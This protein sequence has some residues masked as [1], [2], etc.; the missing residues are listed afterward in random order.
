MSEPVRLPTADSL[1][2]G[3]PG[4]V[5]FHEARPETA[6]LSEPALASAVTGSLA[7]T[8]RV[9]RTKVEAL[10]ED[11]PLRSVGV[12][13]VAPGEGTVTTAFGVAVALAREGAR[14]VLLVEAYLADPVLEDRL[15]LTAARGLGDWLARGADGPVA[16]RRVNPWGVYVLA[17]GRRQPQAGR[18]LETAGLGVLLEAARGAYDH[19]VVACPPLSTGADTVLMQDLLDGLLLVVRARSATRELVQRALTQLKPDR[20]R[21]VVLNDHHEIL[22]RRFSRTRG[23]RG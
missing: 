23:R 11:R 18:L 5:I 17:A 12:V 13:A 1:A 16:V 8:F 6:E 7:E 3:A 15:G 4:H 22:A 14:R 10:D 9:L 2:L 20:V 21:G 19:V